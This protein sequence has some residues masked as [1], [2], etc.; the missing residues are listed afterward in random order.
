MAIPSRRRLPRPPP[1]LSP[2]FRPTTWWD[3]V[4]SDT[5]APIVKAIQVNFD[6]PLAFLLVLGLPI[7]FI[8]Y[9]AF[10]GGRA[11]RFF[12]EQDAARGGQL[13]RGFEEFTSLKKSEQRTGMQSG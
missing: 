5:I 1:P 6:S 3:V 4:Q 7:A 13:G 8:A 11:A 10:L 12:V 2:A 9:G